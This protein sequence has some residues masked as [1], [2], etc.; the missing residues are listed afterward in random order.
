MFP[1]IH[2]LYSNMIYA[3]Y[4]FPSS[5]IPLLKMTLKLPLQYSLSFT[6]FNLPLLLLHYHSLNL[7]CFTFLFF[8]VLVSV[9]CSVE[10]CL[11]TL[12]ENIMCFI[13]TNLLNYS[14]LP[15]PHPV[16]FSSFQ[17]YILPT[18]MWCISLLF[19]LYHSFLHFPSLIF[20]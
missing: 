13:Q 7:T 3:L 15:F 17:C 10:F 4:Y 8:I 14:S 19:I 9:H 18:K 11:G 12:P 20:L 1:S 6:L 2:I 5:P 16:L